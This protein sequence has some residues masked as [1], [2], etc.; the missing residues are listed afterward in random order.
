M[1]A[2]LRTIDQDWRKELADQ[3]KIDGLWSKWQRW[4][5]SKGR[6]KETKKAMSN[7]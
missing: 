3:T 1:E 6:M 4:K 7:Y 2:E 5:S